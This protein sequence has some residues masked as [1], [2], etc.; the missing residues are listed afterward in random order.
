MD[1]LAP[2]SSVSNVSASVPEVT[3]RSTHST[4]TQALKASTVSVSD[5][6]E[7]GV[8]FISL[9]TSTLSSS[10]I[11]NYISVSLSSNITERSS[12]IDGSPVMNQSSE[13]DSTDISTLVDYNVSSDIA[14]DTRMSNTQSF[15]HGSALKTS[16][17]LSS[18]SDL[19]KS[20]SSII[21]VTLPIKSSSV[22][23]QTSLVSLSS[24]VQSYT[25]FVVSSRTSLIRPVSSTPA[26][27]ILSSSSSGPESTARSKFSAKTHLPSRATY[28]ALDEMV[29][30][31][32]ESSIFSSAVLLPNDQYF[33]TSFYSLL[34][35]NETEDDS[36]DTSHALQTSD[37]ADFILSSSERDILTFEQTHAVST[38]QS[39]STNIAFDKYP[40]SS[41]VSNTV[42]NG[43]AILATTDDS[44]DYNG[45][46]GEVDVFETETV[47]N[48]FDAN[49]GLF[50]FLIV[51]VALVVGLF[52]F[53]L[54][55]TIY[56]HR[57]RTW[58]PRKAYEDAY[59]DMVGI[60]HY[61]ITNFNICLF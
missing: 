34:F 38:S 37:F 45:T 33:E 18:D 54:I 21:N 41:T 60:L 15:D 59:A 23:G 29:S 16:T 57:M 17:V 20:D 44:S 32:K 58:H 25:A 26:L 53:G 12:V 8:K 56:Q 7:S 4:V 35:S 61:T 2:L 46:D 39:S 47:G 22:Y 30:A 11:S 42:R 13:V 31:E 27:T 24:N 49:K 36:L 3:D 40:S 28:T 48:V 1:V 14:G 50:I 43:T 10:Y 9:S 19:I 5:L 52:L 55:G 6:S 51:F